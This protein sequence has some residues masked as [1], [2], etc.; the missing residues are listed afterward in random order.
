MQQYLRR[1][2][3]TL[4][5]FAAAVDAFDG[6]R[7]RLATALTDKQNKA[8]ADISERLRTAVKQRKPGDAIDAWQTK[9]CFRYTSIESRPP[10]L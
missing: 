6:T 5:D 3:A 8:L 1:A 4:K 7:A 10:V 9:T 2:N